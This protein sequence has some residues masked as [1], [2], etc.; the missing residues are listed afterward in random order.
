MTVHE[1]L[2]LVSD[3]GASVQVSPEPV[4][5]PVLLVVNLTVPS[6]FTGLPEIV[7]VTVAL[8]VVGELIDTELG[9]QVTSVLVGR[10]FT[11]VPS[12]PELFKL[13]GSAVV[14]ETEAVFE[15]EPMVGRDAT[16]ARTFTTC[17][18]P[19]VI[20]FSDSGLLQLDPA[21]TSQSDAGAA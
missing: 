20:V 11:V 13:F 14:D 8:H 17:D 4:N 16:F 9:E 19:A 2:S 18:V 3:T 1:L 21:L 15:I 6:G 7:S 5:V 10:R 12:V